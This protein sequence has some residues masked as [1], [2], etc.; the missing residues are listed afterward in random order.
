MVEMILSPEI[1][2]VNRNE[3]VTISQGV[4]A[5]VIDKRSADTVVVTP[6]SQTVVIGGLIA[7]LKTE[8]VSKIPLLGDLPV[9]GFAFRSKTKRDTKTELLIFLTPHI[10]QT[11]TQLAALSTKE[12][13]KAGVSKALTEQELNKYLDEVPAATDEDMKKWKNFTPQK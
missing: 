2:T 12:K 8:S 5:P 11:P 4:Q 6:D 10:V 13:E 3:S 1:S 7:N 9:L